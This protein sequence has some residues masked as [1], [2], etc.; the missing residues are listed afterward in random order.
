VAGPRVTPKIG[1]DVLPGAE[2]AVLRYL[3]HG[4]RLLYEIAPIIQ[5]KPRAERRRPS[6]PRFKRYLSGTPAGGF[7]PLATLT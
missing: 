1:G 7:R 2:E 6:L 3:A 4:C 5:D